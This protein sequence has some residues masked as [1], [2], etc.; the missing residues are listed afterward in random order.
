MAILRGILGLISAHLKGEPLRPGGRTAPALQS[1]AVLSSVLG[2]GERLP[3]YISMTIFFPVKFFLLIQFVII[4]ALLWDWYRRR[5]LQTR[6]AQKFALE[7]Q[8]I[9]QRFRELFEQAPIGIALEDPEGKLLFVNPA[10]SSI[11][12][13]ERN[14]MIGMS[15]SR[16]S[17]EATC[18]GE[19][20]L[21]KEL[22]SGLIGTY[23]LQ[24][25][26]IRKDGGRIWGRVS[27]SRLTFQTP[28]A[29]VVLALLEDVTERYEA[30]QKLKEA[31]SALHE[32][33]SRLIAAQEEE[34]QRIA[35]EL[36]DDIGQRLSLLMV[37][38]ERL[39]YKLPRSAGH[40]SAE[41][42]HLLQGMDE[43]ATDVHELSHELHSSKLQHL[44]LQSAL[45]ELCL[46][47]R[48]RDLR[49]VE[50][51]QDVP[52]L[53]SDAQL[54]LYRVAQEAINNVAHHS[55]ASVV[56]VQFS[57]KDT[58]VRLRIRDNGRGFEPSNA[59]SGLGLASMRERVR[60][61]DGDLMIL[62]AES[63][64]V[65]LVATIPLQSKMVLR[66]AG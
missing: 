27:V 2:D 58:T 37:D 64:G 16:L 54:C 34:R 29:P 46:H 7:K 12:G 24:K 36:H 63:H 6:L 26:F 4:V 47:L 31:E 44:G 45:K 62:A 41:F 23:H 60:A 18:A 11:L 35:R 32:L 22:E 13:Y 52:E 42:L 9:E 30:D 43:I 5:L 28:G 48:Q 61:L 49:V 50:E 21:L 33:P 65:E 38:L 39:I 17:D 14:E 66:K 15:C 40:V 57:R 59:T 19:G 55:H 51:I 10:L 53:P 8:A 56:W 1:P 25:Q 3:I 20:E